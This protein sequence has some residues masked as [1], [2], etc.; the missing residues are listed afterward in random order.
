MNTKM[1]PM[2]IINGPEINSLLNFKS[3]IL[4]KSVILKVSE[5]NNI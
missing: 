5:R 4:N 1:Y 2:N 3:I